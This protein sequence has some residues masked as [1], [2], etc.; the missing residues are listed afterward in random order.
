MA[1][2]IMKGH[3]FCCFDPDNNRQE[4]IDKFRLKNHIFVHFLLFLNSSIYIQI[5]DIKVE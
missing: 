3:T 1:V 2:L 5:K 4:R